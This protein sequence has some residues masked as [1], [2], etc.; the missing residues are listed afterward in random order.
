MG[1][2]YKDCQA[3]KLIS[4]MV[5]FLYRSLCL[6]KKVFYYYHTNEMEAENNGRK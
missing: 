1:L 4:L 2:K 6:Y 3:A 5:A